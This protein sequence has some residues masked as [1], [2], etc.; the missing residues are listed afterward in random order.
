MAIKTGWQISGYIVPVSRTCPR[1]NGQMLKRTGAIHSCE[2]HPWPRKVDCLANGRC[3][4]SSTLYPALHS[5][6]PFQGEVTGDC[7]QASAHG[8][9]QRM[10]KIFTFTGRDERIP[11]YKPIPH[12]IRESSRV[13]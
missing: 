10:S 7:G 13:W 12:F 11:G 3:V 5:F 6:K 1:P 2:V 9:Y 4:V 8:F